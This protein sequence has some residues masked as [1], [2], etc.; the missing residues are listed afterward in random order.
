MKLDSKKL[1][2]AKTLNV[3][4]GRIKFDEDRLEEIKEAITK[5]D[6]RDLFA[7]GA[8]KIKPIKGRKSKEKRKT[9]KRGGKVRIKVNTRK[10]D[11]VIITRKLRRYVKELKLQGKLDD[12]KYKDLRKMI[13]RKEFKNKRH[14]KEAAL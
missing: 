1:L 4:I 13:K 10:Q 5:Q 8:V 11:Y 6:I 9:R 3:G 14:L 2:A 7:S 12:E